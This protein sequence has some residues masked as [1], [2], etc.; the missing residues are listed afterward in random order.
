MSDLFLLLSAAIIFFGTINLIRMV[1]FLVG[2]DIYNLYYHFKYR[3]QLIAPAPSV[4][5]V[6]PAYN[7][8][9]S[10]IRCVQ[11]ILDSDYPQS[12][13]EIIVVND[14]SKDRTLE[15][16]TQ[17]Q[18]EH[19]VKNLKIIDQPNLGKAHALNNGMKNHA[20]GEL[21][22]CLDSDSSLDKNALK[23][24]GFYFQDPKVVAL[25]AN[26]KITKTSGL[27]NLVQTFEYIVCYQMK[28]AQTVFN[29][30]YIIGGIGSTFRRSYLAKIGYY[31]GNTI[32][33]DIDLTMKILQAGNKNVRVIYGS[34][35]IAYTQS[36]LTLSE[37]IRQRYRWKWGRSQTFYK[38]QDMFFNS[39][40][41]F[42]KLFTYIYLPYAIFS[43]IA[44]FL[45]PIILTFLVF[46]SIYY[47]DF[48]TLISA[49][50]VFC[51]YLSFNILAEDTIKLSE[52]IKLIPL[53]PIIYILFFILSYAEYLALIKALISAPTLRQ[54]LTK[55]INKWQPVER[56]KLTAN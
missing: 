48:I 5:I 13:I 26:V 51:I 46:I 50:F 25:S 20:T 56:V 7:E 3:N 15:L 16:I 30:E 52:K 43:D 28:R 21:V 38:N 6:I 39:D 18:A 34:K 45:E 40:S 17:F 54:S 37:L 32:T 36:V 33:E 24:L 14:G 4:S 10:I 29:I 49:V 12:L 35:V 19:Q 27:M 31:D 1:A 8:A 42:T 47:R 53:T 11:S 9:N 2:S 44:F 41:R 55:N 22:M 23:N